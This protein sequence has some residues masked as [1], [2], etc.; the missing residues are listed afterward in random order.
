MSEAPPEIGDLLADDVVVFRA[1][2]TKAY[3]ERPKRIRSGAY[4]RSMSHTD[5]LSLGLTPEDAIAGLSRNF[6]YCSVTVG[7]IH[8][9]PYGLEVRAVK[10]QPGHVLLLKMPCIDG[11]D[12]QRADAAEISNKLAK[13]SVLQSCDSYP[14]TADGPPLPSATQS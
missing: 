9:L 1:F 8:K 3:R 14:P 5:G 12:D 7:D 11:D 10:N 6:G 4:Y 13:I 2:A